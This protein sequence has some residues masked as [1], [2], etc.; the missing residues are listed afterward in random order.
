MPEVTLAL[1]ARRA[2]VHVSTVSRALRNDPRIPARTRQRLQRLAVRLGYRPN[3][4]VS[5]LM[6][7]R[8]AANPRT[9][10][11]TLAY[12]TA[13]PTRRGWREYVPNFFP[14]ALRRSQELGYRLED[15]WLHEPG[16]SPARLADILLARGIRG[17]IIS[18]TPPGLSRLEFPWEQF[19]SVSLGVTLEYPPTHHVAHHHFDDVVAT[20][21][22]CR[23]LGYRR[24]GLALLH[25]QYPRSQQRWLGAFRACQRDLPERDR[26]EPCQLAQPSARAL[27]AWVRRERVDVIVTGEVEAAEQGLRAAGLRVPRDV[28][29]ACLNLFQRDERRAGMYHDPARTG[30]VAVDMVTAQLYRNETGLPADPAEV[31]LNGHWQDGASLPPHL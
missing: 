26:V 4:L 24:V 21:A 6:Q 2:G 9:H 30:V 15:F 5:A 10:H 7:L 19:A 12:L 18:R 3:P 1:L 22:H 27:A 17:I 8:R 29:L 11:T 14:G 13:F 23:A 25:F 16:M 20:L 28:A 31:L